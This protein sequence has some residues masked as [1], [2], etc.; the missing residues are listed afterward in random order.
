MTVIAGYAS[1]FN[2][3]DTDRDVI[4]KGAFKNLNKRKI[5]L[6]WQHDINKIIGSVDYFV[7]DEF[8][9][10]IKATLDL[11]AKDSRHVASL[12]K[13]NKITGLSIGFKPIRVLVD[14]LTKTRTI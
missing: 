7:E 4:I 1:V 9:L 14:K 6:L 3:L 10:Y 5:L 11:Q 2:I 12:I 13:E 8:G